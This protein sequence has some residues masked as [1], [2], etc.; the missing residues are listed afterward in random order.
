MV[1]PVT[2]PFLHPDGYKL[3]PFP[4]VRVS[5]SS[6][7]WNLHRVPL[8]RLPILNIT[9]ANAAIVGE[10][11]NSHVSSQIS[12]RE[13]AALTKTAKQR[14]AVDVLAHI[15]DTLHT[16]MTHATG[17]HAQG[18]PPARVIVL[19]RDDATPNSDLSDAILFFIDKLRHDV[20]AHTVVCDAFALPLSPELMRTTVGPLVT[21]LLAHPPR[22]VV[23]Q[24]V[25]AHGGETEMRAWRRQ[26]LP[27]LVERCCTTWTHGPNC[28]YRDAAT[29]NLKASLGS[30][31]AEATT[32]EG[33]PLCSC[34]RGKDVD[35]M[36]QAKD[37]LWEKFVP[38]V[39]RVALSPLFAVSY[40]EP[41]LGGHDS[42]DDCGG[43]GDGDSPV[44]VPASSRARPRRTPRSAAGGTAKVSGVRCKKCG[45]EEAGE[46]K[47]FRCSGCKTAVYCSEACQ[48]SDWKAHKVWCGK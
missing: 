44:A 32:G 38:F 48:K 27:P 40:V 3:S 12:V 34:G 1:V 26:L 22:G 31:A 43:G 21:E 42:D 47:L 13:R 39:T 4:V 45:K 37:D 28:E 14:D 36:L 8:D 17:A 33:D 20:A 24:N 16:I 11:F 2:I 23:I 18:A 10:W 5:Q 15:K 9:P 30:E 29:G 35:G 19:R 7:A 41:V 6:V 25:R 46:V